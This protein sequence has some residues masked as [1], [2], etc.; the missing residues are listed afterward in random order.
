LGLCISTS[1]GKPLFVEYNYVTSLEI[2]FGGLLFFI[3]IIVVIFFSDFSLQELQ[4]LGGMFVPLG[5]VG[6]L[7]PN[8]FSLFVVIVVFGIHFQFIDQSQIFE[9][10]FRWVYHTL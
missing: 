3:I 7:I 1:G 9:F 4:D 10:Q 8:G 2:A 6:R 5:R